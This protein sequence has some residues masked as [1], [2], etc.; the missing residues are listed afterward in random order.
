MS[1][2]QKNLKVIAIIGT[3]VVASGVVITAIV[4][5]PPNVPTDRITVTLLYNAGVMI[6]VEDTRIYIDPCDLPSNY[7]NYPA[8][9]IFITHDHG[10][11]YDPSSIDIIKS[12]TTRLFVPAIMSQQAAQY[13]PESVQPEDAVVCDDFN[14]SCFYMYTMPGS[15]ESSHPQESNYV[16]YI[17]ELDGFTM[18]HAGDSWNINE[19][20]QLNGKIDLVFLPL[21]PGCQTMTEI[22]VVRVVETIEP[23]YFIPIHFTADTKQL[24]VDLYTANVEACGCQLINLDYYEAYGVN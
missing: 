1:F 2:V 14:V 11:H 23:R 17:I 4:L 9:Y 22:D 18:F 21:G 24:F 5:N 6:E 19:Y 12:E 15:N 20:S 3:I 13:V 7:S 16:S 8:D 10:D